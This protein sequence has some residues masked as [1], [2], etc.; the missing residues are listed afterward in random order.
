MSKHIHGIIGSTGDDFI[1][2]DD[3]YNVVWGRYGND[4]IVDRTEDGQDAAVRNS[5]YAGMDGNDTIVTFAGHDH[6][7]GG[8]G[9]DT[10]FAYNTDNFR[11]TGGKGH[12]VLNVVVDD[13]SLYQDMILNGDEKLKLEVGD[14]IIHVR[15]MEEVHFVDHDHGWV[16]PG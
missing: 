11:V 3:A 8:S 6:L 9:D 14:Q 16:M 10:F 5:T 7:R 12:D 4:T 2:N 13:P 15:K 1:F